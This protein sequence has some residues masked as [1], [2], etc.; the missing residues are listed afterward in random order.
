MTLGSMEVW[1]ILLVLFSPYLI[2]RFTLGFLISFCI[3][4]VNR[5]S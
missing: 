3:R 4:S 2:F 1:D 5:S